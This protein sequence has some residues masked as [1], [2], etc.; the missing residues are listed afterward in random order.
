MCKITF[1]KIDEL[2]DPQRFV[3]ATFDSEYVT[4]VK[5][6]KSVNEPEVIAKT[7]CILSL[8]TWVDDRSAS[9]V[10]G[11]DCK[12]DNRA[13]V[14]WVTWAEHWVLLHFVDKNKV[15]NHAFLT[16]E[17]LRK[18]VKEMEIQSLKLRF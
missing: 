3:S 14:F 8:L 7:E 10:Y 15:V 17:S 4:F 16:V 5:L 13:N 12:T 6:E 18:L 11:F 2:H 9:R 1:D